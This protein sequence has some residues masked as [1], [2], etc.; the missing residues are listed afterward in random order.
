VNRFAGSVQQPFEGVVN[1]HGTKTA[2]ACPRTT[3]GHAAA[4]PSAAMNSRRFI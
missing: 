4:L 2:C 3:T 1:P